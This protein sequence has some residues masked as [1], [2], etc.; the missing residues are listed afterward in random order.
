MLNINLL[1]DESGI[2]VFWFNGQCIYV[3]KAAQQT[4]KERLLQHYRNCHNDNLRLW[5][6]VYGCQLQFCFFQL[7]TNRRIDFL[8]KKFIYRLQP[9][10]NKTNK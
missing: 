10:A 8:E 1:N 5:I 7:S 6:E 9:I 2:Y 4:L 3:G